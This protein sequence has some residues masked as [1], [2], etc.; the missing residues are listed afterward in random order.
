MDSGGFFCNNKECRK[1][2]SGRAWATVCSHVFCHSCGSKTLDKIPTSCPACDTLLKKQFEALNLDLDPSDEFKSMIVAGLRPETILEI[3]QRG[4]SF[5]TYQKYQD[6]LFNEATIQALTENNEILEKHYQDL[7]EKRERDLNGL[8]SQLE[9]RVQD[10]ERLQKRVSELTEILAEKAR[11]HQK[12][13]ATNEDY[14]RKLEFT[15]LGNRLKTGDNPIATPASERRLQGSTMGSFRYDMTTNVTSKVSEA[16]P[17]TMR[18]NS[19]FQK[20]H[21]ATGKKSS[22]LNVTFD[23][24]TFRK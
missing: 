18:G 20:P 15:T 4:M 9:N 5:W 8:K 12:L 22:D 23:Y 3:A 24:G 19:V 6:L 21:T 17:R 16:P 13:Q 2:I 11:Q 14:R 10:I 1:S 7:I